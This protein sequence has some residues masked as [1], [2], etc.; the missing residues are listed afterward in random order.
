[1]NSATG[2]RSARTWARTSRSGSQQIGSG[3]GIDTA[4]GIASRYYAWPEVAF[5]PL[6]DAAPATLVL[7]RRSENNDRLVTDFIHLAQEVSAT[8]AA[9]DTPYQPATI[10]LSPARS[11][12]TPPEF[13]AQPAV[14]NVRDLGGSRH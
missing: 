14:T 8:A 4:P 10:Q 11:H 6:Q 3:D 1:M 12:A 13:V 7:A 2:P 9:A 5:V